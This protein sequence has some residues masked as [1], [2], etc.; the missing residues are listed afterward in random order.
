MIQPFL[1]GFAALC[2]KLGIY[3]PT[4]INRSATLDATTYAAVF[5]ILLEAIDT[6]TDA[7]VTDEFPA[8]VARQGSLKATELVMAAGADINQCADALRKNG[9]YLEGAVNFVPA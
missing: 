7:L 1:N 2:V 3:T 4:M 6:G 9:I 8:S 5:G